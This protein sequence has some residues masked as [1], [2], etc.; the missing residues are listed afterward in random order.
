MKKLLSIFV[1]LCVGTLSLAQTIHPDYTDGKLYVRLNAN[2]TPAIGKHPDWKNLPISG[3]SFLKDLSSPFSITKVSKP[4]FAAKG[5]D[6]LLRTYVVHFSNYASYQQLI[7]ALKQTGSVELAERV[8]LMKTSLTPNDYTPTGNPSQWFLAKINAPA[9][10]DVFSAGSTV[11]VAVVD[12]AV[13]TNHPDLSANMYTNT[14]EIAGNGIDDDNNGFIDDVM[15]YDVGDD[16]NNANPLNTSFDHGTHC[17]GLVSARTNNGTGIASIGFSVRIIPVKATSDASDPTAVDAGYAGVIY[18]VNAKARVISCSW[19]GGGNSVTEQAVMNYAW[20][21]NSIVVAAAGNDNVSTQNYPGA[22]NNVYCVASTTSTDAKSSFSNYG[23]WVDISAPGSTIRSTLPGNGYGNMSGTSMATPIVAGLCGLMLSKSPYLTPTQVL[24]CISTTAATLT[25]SGM[26]AGRIDAAAA[27]NCAATAIAPSPTVNFTTN[28]TVTCP[29]SPVKF[30]DQTYYLPTSW[31]WTFTGG[32]PSTSTLQN[33]VVTYAAAGTY[34]VQLIATNANGN[35]T[36]IKTSYITVLGPTILPLVEGFS[37][38][39][40]PPAGWADYDYYGDSV[41]WYRNTSVGGFTA[42]GACMFF[43]NYNSDTRGKADDIKTPKYDFTGLTTASLTFDVAYA[44]YDAE[45]SDSLAVLVSTDCGE[46]YTQV[47]FKGGTGLSTAA[48]NA[49]A[50]F[51]PA[52]T[53][54]RTE[55]VNLNSFVGQGNV[56][57]A[58]RNIGRYGQAIYVDNVN[59]SGVT[60]GAPPTALFSASS[61]NC[62]GQTVTLTDNSTNNPTSWS[63]STTGGTL[64]STTDQSPTIVFNTSGTYTITHTATNSFGTSSVASQTLIIN[65]TPTATASNTGPFCV[66]GSI[67]LSSSG[68]TSYSWA[69]PGGYNSTLQNPVRNSVTLS[70]G[71]IY[72]VTVTDNG[73]SSTSTTTVAVNNKP[74][75]SLSGPNSFCAGDSVTLTGSGAS[76]GGFVISGYQWQMGGSPIVGATAVT[77]NATA[78]GVYNVIVTNSGGCSTTSANKTITVNALPTVVAN[79]NTST[80]ICSGDAIIL[81]GSGTATSYVWNNGVINGQSFVPASSQSYIVTGTSSAN[82]SNRDTIEITVNPCVGIN[83]VANENLV[84]IFPNPN[85]G[86]FEISLGNTS[87]SKLFIINSTGQLIYNNNEVNENRVKLENI[88]S[89]IYMIVITTKTNS[90]VSKK[91]IVK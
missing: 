31:S 63:W 25:T 19:G 35:G 80:S 76:G 85:D 64:S 65:Q 68:G 82:C 11:A 41:K 50:M 91:V 79:I 58:F 2:S 61:N 78:A 81:T 33:P 57:V 45:Y 70:M 48:D 24:S 23:T 20:S 34:S 74:T 47:Y 29:G 21:R 14:G 42:T 22:Y 86:E 16:D 7:D 62:S 44:R 49:A 83:E 5:S 30:Y 32:T 8:P 17:A 71:G 18:A 10:W 59:I 4:F 52:A 55:T 67:S 66:Q 56:L 75:A 54:W 37:T 72:T 12:N 38:Q 88:A 6:E 73:C 69:G 26:G 51:Q 84:S 90:I 15:G 89:G 53:E 46:T 28:T 43:D 77:Y 87:V 27:M 3:F 39:V 1:G 60:A 9:A 36:E 40:F 13:Q